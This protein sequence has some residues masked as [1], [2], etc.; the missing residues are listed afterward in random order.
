MALKTRPIRYTTCSVWLTQ[1]DYRRLCA[2]SMRR[3]NQQRALCQPPT[4]ITLQAIIV[5][6]IRKQIPA[7]VD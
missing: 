4:R 6:A 7:A 5:D 1:D 3:F 2:E